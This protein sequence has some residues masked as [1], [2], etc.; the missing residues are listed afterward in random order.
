[1]EKEL[2]QG[3]VYKLI[4]PNEYFYIG[5]TKNSLENRFCGHRYDCEN[6]SNS[7]LYNYIKN[8][9]IDWKDI[10]IKLIDYLECD[11]IIDLRKLENNYIE[12]EKNNN[13]CL[14][15]NLAI[16]I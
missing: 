12:K 6:R 8:N 10:L 14:N 15:E 7:K 2:I 9:K 4:L 13:L 16:I 5:S 3:K 1:M 11:N